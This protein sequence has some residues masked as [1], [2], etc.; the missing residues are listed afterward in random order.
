M[1][2]KKGESGN[3]QGRPPGTGDVAS[4]RAALG[5][6]LPAVISAMVD[7]AKK[8]DT[9]AARLILERTVPPLRPEEMS[10]KLDGVRG[11][12]ADMV[13]AIIEALV[14]GDLDVSRGGRAY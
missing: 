8:G 1:V 6:H 11:S 5:E 12:R 13:N 4:L 3:P 7:A 10:V 9:A 2:W 14:N